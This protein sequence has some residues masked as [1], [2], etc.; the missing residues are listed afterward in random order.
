MSNR[1]GGAGPLGTMPARAR[2]T[3][4]EEKDL[5]ERHCRGVAWAPGLIG[6]SVQEAPNYGRANGGGVARWVGQL[7]SGAAIVLVGHDHVYARFGSQDAQGQP[8]PKR[9]LRRFTV[10]TG[11]GSICMFGAPLPNSEVREAATFGVPVLTLCKNR[12]EWEYVPVEWDPFTDRG[13]GGC[14]P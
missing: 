11:S 10:G 4:V 1:Q 12:C 9:G 7:P 2:V 13:G 6:G 8:D 3:S 14:H 5:D